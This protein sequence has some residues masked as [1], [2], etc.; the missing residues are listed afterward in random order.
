MS[1]VILILAVIFMIG[2]NAWVR[3][4]LETLNGPPSS[5]ERASQPSNKLKALKNVWV[6][7]AF[8][9]IFFRGGL[10]LAAI[11][12]AVVVIGLAISEGKRFS[13][14]GV[15]KCNTNIRVFCNLALLCQVVGMAAIFAWYIRMI[16]GIT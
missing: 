11:A 9:I 8:P 7:I 14:L 12:S 3:W 13:V 2:P 4:R 16:Y 5:G 1:A 10:V 15:N 6:I